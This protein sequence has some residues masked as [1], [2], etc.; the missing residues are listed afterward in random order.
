[1]EYEGDPDVKPRIET[2][3]TVDHVWHLKLIRIL[4][5]GEGD[6]AAKKFVAEHDL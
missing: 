5:P 6:L 2:R 3:R 1:M 4:N